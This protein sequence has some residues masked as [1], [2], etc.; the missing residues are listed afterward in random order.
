MPEL[1]GQLVPREFAGFFSQA[2]KHQINPP[3]HQQWYAQRKLSWNIKTL[4]TR[5]CTFWHRVVCSVGAY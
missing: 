3:N 1:A 5:F 4:H 2:S